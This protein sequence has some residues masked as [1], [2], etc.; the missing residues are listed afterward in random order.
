MD[1]IQ[2]KFHDNQVEGLL[3]RNVKYGLTESVKQPVYKC[4]LCGLN[5]I[6]LSS[7]VT[8]RDQI[9][10]Q[11]PPQKFECATCKK[12]F[13]TEADCKQCHPKVTNNRLVLMRAL[14]Q[15]KKVVNQESKKVEA[16]K[17]RTTNDRARNFPKNPAQCPQLIGKVAVTKKDQ[18]SEKME[19]NVKIEEELN[20]LDESSEMVSSWVQ[21]SRQELIINWIFQVKTEPIEEET[22][23][24][25]SLKKSNLIS[26][27]AAPNKV[28]VFDW[29]RFNG[30]LRSCS[31]IIITINL[32]KAQYI[33]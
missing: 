20:I 23:E 4:G 33:S 12:T 14:H 7:L 18:L 2:D 25:S 8:H 10:G 6:F 24:S 13:A 11:K 29:F 22:S 16:K 30:F 28:G 15:A 3:R 17:D 21:D 32:F 27:P 5:L 9:H 19:P 26:S 31:S 1:L